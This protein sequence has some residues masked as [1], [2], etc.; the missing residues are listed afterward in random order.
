MTMNGDSYCGIYCGSCPILRHGETGR[1]DAFIECCGG[2]PKE[3]LACGG[4]KSERVYAGCRVCTF[5][6]C[7]VERGVEHCVECADYPCKQYEKWASMAKLLPHLCE[8]K[9]NLEA[10]RLDGTNAWLSAQKTRWACPNCG[11]PFS[12]Y[13]RACHAC[14]RDLAKEAYAM[15]GLRRLLCK[16]VLPRVY[17]KG[18]SKSPNR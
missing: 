8:A 2:V 6:D 13:E 18:K 3:E 1:A 14:G 4:C 5:R 10:I 15:K 16:L 9:G 7:A 17:A 12:W 11:A